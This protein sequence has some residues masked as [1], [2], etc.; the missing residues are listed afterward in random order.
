MGI[1]VNQAAFDY[2]RQLIQSGKVN[3]EHGIWGESNPDTE[4]QDAF[5]S[6]HGM[7]AWGKW[8]L[9]IKAGGSYGEKSTYSFPY[10]DYKLVFRS[11]LLAAE[12]RAQQYNHLAVRD[13]ARELLELLDSETGEAKE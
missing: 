11:G 2:A 4:A 5:I 3:T 1:E 8:H 9:G 7:E 6:E 13:A 12:E 10:G